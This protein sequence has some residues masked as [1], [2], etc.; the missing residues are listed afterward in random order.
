MSNNCPCKEDEVQMNSYV[1]SSSYLAKG[2]NNIKDQLQNPDVCKKINTENIQSNTHLLHL[3]HENNNIYVCHGLT[4]FDKLSENGCKREVLQSDNTKYVNIVKRLSNISNNVSQITGVKSMSNNNVNTINESINNIE[5]VLTE[6]KAV[7]PR[8]T[9]KIEDIEKKSKL[10]MI[11]SNQLSTGDNP[12]DPK[13][14]MCVAPKKIENVDDAN[15]CK[16]YCMENENCKGMTWYGDDEKNK[17][18]N[19]CFIVLDKD[20]EVVDSEDVASVFIKDYVEKTP[21]EQAPAQP[22]EQAP[23]QPAEQ[24]PAQPAEPAPAAK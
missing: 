3:P 1:C 20:C 12:K 24:A 9:V 14:L 10:S 13:R 7:V 22:A 21:A 23:A 5:K 8:S 2:Y 18:K 4:H 17:I 11:Q 15:M 6:I 16:K 19:Q